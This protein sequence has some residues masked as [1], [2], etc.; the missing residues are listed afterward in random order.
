MTTQADVR[1]LRLSLFPIA[2]LLACAPA[3]P[4]RGMEPVVAER[5]YFGRNIG[6]TLGV[7]DSAWT[8]FVTDVV[9]ARLP[10]GFTVW[11]AEG[12]WRGAD[13]RS[14][15]EPSFV[16]EVVH[17]PRSPDMDAAILAIIAEYKR[18]FGQEAVL[19]VVT[20]GRVTY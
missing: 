17:P 7:S 9:S 20:L 14:R 6:D 11:K 16:L 13:G 2:L 10:R 8:V 18:R 19:R 4:S 15:R 3:M 1:L 12:Q 5:L